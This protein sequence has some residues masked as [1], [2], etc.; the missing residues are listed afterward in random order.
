M[1]LRKCSDEIL[2]QKRA[3]GKLAFF[4]PIRILI[5]LD[6]IVSIS[7]LGL[8]IKGQQEKLHG[9]PRFSCHDIVT[10]DTMGHRVPMLCID[11]EHVAAWLFGINVNKGWPEIRSKLELYQKES[12]LQ[13]TTACALVLTSIRPT[14]AVTMPIKR[15]QYW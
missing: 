10:R 4:L 8:N 9:D 2:K 14:L 13:S 3:G 11:A 1:S 7:F 15:L 6:G 5:D 12:S